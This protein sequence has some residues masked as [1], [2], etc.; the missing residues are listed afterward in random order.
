MMSFDPPKE[1]VHLCIDLFYSILC[2][3]PFSWQKF[4]TLTGSPTSLQLS[5]N[6]LPACFPLSLPLPIFTGPPQR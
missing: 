6:S 2:F 3:P 5:V 1:T 4:R